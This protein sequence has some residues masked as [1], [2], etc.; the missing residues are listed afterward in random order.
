[1]WNNSDFKINPFSNLSSSHDHHNTLCAKPY[2]VFTHWWR[3]YRIIS[4]LYARK[5]GGKFIL[6]IEDTDLE[7]S[8]QASVDA[9]LEAMTWLSLDYDAGPFYQTQ[10]FD[11]YKA[12]IQQLLDQGDAYR[13]C[14]KEALEEMRTAQM[15]N[16]EKPRYDGRCRHNAEVR[17]GVQEAQDVPNA[18]IAGA[19]AC[20]VVRF[21]N[22]LEGEVVIDD[23]VKGRIVVAN[24]ELDDLII[25]RSDGSPTYNL[26]VVVDD[27]DMAI[28][29]VIRGDDH[30]NNTPTDMT[31]KALNATLPQYAHVPMILGADGARLSKRRTG[32]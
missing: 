19:H 7:R 3:P 12:I 6:R 25:A 15:D 30:V 21:K 16:K 13:Y 24:K 22:P 32:R 23:L 10:H 31:F 26:T 14:S 8:T 11:R 17:D 29:H 28:T 20:P 1:M 5:S 4:W 18:G 27:M 9:I 2:R